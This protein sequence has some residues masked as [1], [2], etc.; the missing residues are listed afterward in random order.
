[1]GIWTGLSCHRIG[2]G[3]GRILV[4]CEPSGSI[5]FGEF[6]DSLQTS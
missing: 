5:K 2:T 3:V 6:L 4:H 1:M